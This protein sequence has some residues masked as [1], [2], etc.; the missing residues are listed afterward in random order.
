MID[1][2]QSK[3]HNPC[4]PIQPVITDQ[5]GTYRFRANAVVTYLLDWASKRGCNLNDLARV[6]FNEDDTQQF[7]QLIGYSLSGYGE[8]SYASDEVYESALLMVDGTLSEDKARIDCLEQELSVYK[9]EL[10]VLQ[11]LF[12]GPVAR[13]YEVEHE[14]LLP[15][16][17]RVSAGKKWIE[18]HHQHKAEVAE[19]EKRKSEAEMYRAED[20]LKRER[21]RAK[22]AEEQR[23]LMRKWTDSGRETLGGANRLFDLLVSS[24]AIRPEK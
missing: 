14:D 22:I 24:G 19:A 2:T 20:E 15:G 5:H 16:E 12:K 8:L 18:Q 21:R 10:A 23:E 1:Q 4:H 13:L 6:R 7:A 17:Q 3:P 11:D 9:K